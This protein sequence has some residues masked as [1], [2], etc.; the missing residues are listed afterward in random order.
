MRSSQSLNT[1]GVRPGAVAP[2]LPRQ[3]HPGAVCVVSPMG[4]VG[5]T[6][7]ACLLGYYL[8]RRTRKRVLLIDADPACS[9]S[10]AYGFG[11]DVVNKPGNTI[12]NLLRPG[13]W[14]RGMKPELGKY[15]FQPE[16]K[17]TPPN[18]R[19]IPGNFHLNGLN[20]EIGALF[21]RDGGKRIGQFR[22]YC[23]RVVR[24]LGDEYEYVV[25]DCPPAAT[26]LTTAMLYACS[27]YLAVLRPEK[28]AI[29]GMSHLMQWAAGAGRPRCLGYVLNN[30]GRAATGVAVKSRAWQRTARDL[31]ARVLSLLGPEE[32]TVLG[33]APSLGEV[34]H[35][36]AVARFF[37]LDPKRSFVDLRRRTP[38]PPSVHKC[39]TALVTKVVQRMEAYRE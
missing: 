25:V 29:Y 7:I 21:D 37:M 22:D 13:Q 2:Q 35:L 3:R 27:C 33:A 18:L 26:I 24:T 19:V 1:D 8:A 5:K 15:A 23:G 20:T 36:D 34:P 6:T 38:G 4:G 12:Y 17:G 10:I 31:D 39:V 14:L 32:K 30:P 16:L 11:P 28:C 9:M